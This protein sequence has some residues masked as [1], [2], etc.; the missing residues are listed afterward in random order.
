M[1]NRED[2][3]PNSRGADRVNCLRGSPIDAVLVAGPAVFVIEFKVG[4]A[5]V[6][7]PDTTR[8]SVNAERFSLRRYD[9][10]VVQTAQSVTLRSGHV[11][12][13]AFEITARH[14]ERPS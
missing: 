10:V 7:P 12:E 3:L 9:G 4:A 6:L 8:R 1:D 14:F 5:D 11:R 13:H 2:S